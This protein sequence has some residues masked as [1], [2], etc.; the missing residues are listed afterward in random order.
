MKKVLF[1]S[2][3]TLLPRTFIPGIAGFVFSA[4][5][6]RA[7]E[8]SLHLWSTDVSVA[9]IISLTTFSSFSSLSFFLSLSRRMRTMRTKRRRRRTMRKMMRSCLTKSYQTTKNSMLNRFAFASFLPS[10][11]KQFAK[12]LLQ[13][14]RSF[15]SS[16]CQQHSSSGPLA[17]FSSAFESWN[18]GAHISS[19]LCTRRSSG[20]SPDIFDSEC[21]D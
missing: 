21:S 19:A 10:S 7:I 11:R 17:R 16:C 6:G 15:G 2:C 14:K 20:P 1:I 4:C 13:E 12:G 18:P 3:P 5:L 8:K 9:V